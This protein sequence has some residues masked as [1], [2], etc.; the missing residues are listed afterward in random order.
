MAPKVR[1]DINDEK[2]RNIAGRVKEIV[3][4]LTATTIFAP[5]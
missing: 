1:L 5:I 4:C 2:T 3:E